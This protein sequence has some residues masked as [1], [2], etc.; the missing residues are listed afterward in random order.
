MDVPR[1]VDVI[2]ENKRIVIELHYAFPR[3]EEM[4]TME[5]DDVVRVSFGE[6]SGRVYFVECDQTL[7]IDA[8]RDSLRQLQSL[9]AG[10]DGAGRPQRR[11][12][13]YQ[14]IADDVL[15]YVV[16]EVRHE[17]MRESR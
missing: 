13:H 9:V 11:V 2:R 8:V 10:T 4:R 6:D 12:A 15:P 7:D 14:L 17:L 3:Q 5:R 1:D 16:Q